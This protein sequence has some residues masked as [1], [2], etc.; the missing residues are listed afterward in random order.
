MN[1]IISNT[2]DKPIY[3]QLYEQISAQVLTGRLP[4]GFVLPPIRQAA[5]ELG[6]S[7]ITVKKA[8]DELEHNGFINT[9]TGKGCFV[10]EL[11]PEAIAQMREALVE[12]QMKKDLDYYL[13]L[14]LSLEE[15]IVLLRKVSS[16]SSQ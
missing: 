6:I 4:S 12:S 8:W 5:K 15:I 3:Q 2:S 9:V 16:Q 1:I 10:A 14:G 7:I 13:S 11:S